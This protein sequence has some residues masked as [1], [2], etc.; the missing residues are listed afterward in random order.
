MHRRRDIAIGLTAAAVAAL[1]GCAGLGRPDAVTLSEADLARLLGRVFPLDRRV[2]EV[3]D[4]SVDAPR[5]TLLPER[6]RLAVAAA[7]TGRD[8]LFGGSW[9]ARLGFDSALRYEPADQTLRLAQVRVN[10]L[11]LDSGDMA[12]HAVV[13]RVAP[14]LAERML[15]DLV[16]YR[17]TPERAQELARQGVRPKSVAVTRGGVEIRFEPVP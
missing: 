7:A 11:T 9:R 14:L 4:V 6:N 17:L 3:L 13:Q 12:Q 2:L 15:D 10:E 16:I 5:L 8:R 1:A